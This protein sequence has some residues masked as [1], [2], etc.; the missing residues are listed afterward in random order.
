MIFKTI[1]SVASFAEE[2]Q[3]GGE[4]LIWPTETNMIWPDLRDVDLNVEEWV[5]IAK[6]QGIKFNC[7]RLVIHYQLATA[8][9]T[10]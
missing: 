2:W 10:L 6:E 4:K 7:G 3:A 8:T 9:K 1:G 5:R